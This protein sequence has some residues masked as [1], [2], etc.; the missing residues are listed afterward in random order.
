MKLCPVCGSRYSDDTLKFCLQDGT[1]L[2]AARDGEMPTAVL[3]EVETAE[4]LGRGTPTNRNE[5]SQDR[6]TKVPPTP[7]KTRSNT[8]IAVVLTAL[9][10]LILFGIVGIASWFFSSNKQTEVGVN[11]ANRSGENTDNPVIPPPKSSATPVP[12]PLKV[13]AAPPPVN[14][15]SRTEILTTLDTWKGKSESLDLDS[16]MTHYASTVDYYNKSRASAAFVRADKQRAF[17]RYT[18]IIVNLS[19][20]TVTTGADGETAT[21]IFDKEWEFRGNGSSC[22]KVRQLMRLARVGGQWLITA[23]KDLQLYHK[24]C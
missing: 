13:N 22:G 24:R 20:V 12:S 21:A 5:W 4:A 9:G 18:S 14:S 11:T 23:E 2:Y 6:D 8:A 1:P 16:Y 15:A 7:P 19:N 10:M 17:T 3:G